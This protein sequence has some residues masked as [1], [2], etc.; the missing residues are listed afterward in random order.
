MNELFV[1]Y[2]VMCVGY[3]LWGVVNVFILVDD[4]FSRLC[5]LLFNL[6]VVR[7]CCVIWFCLLI[8]NMVGKVIILSFVVKCLLRL[9]FL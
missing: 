1:L 8:S 9:F 2:D 6:V 3:L 5:S 4:Y 7:L